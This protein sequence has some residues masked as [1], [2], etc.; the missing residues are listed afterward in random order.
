[1]YD[2]CVVGLVYNALFWLMSAGVGTVFSLTR[3]SQKSEYSPRL[4]KASVRDRCHG[5]GK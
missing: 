3:E 5:V 1:V 2:A 4:W